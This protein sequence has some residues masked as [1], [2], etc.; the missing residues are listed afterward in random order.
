GRAALE[1][2]PGE[3]GRQV[4]A[5]EIAEPVAEAR[6]EGN[7][8][9]K[10][11]FV[12]ILRHAGFRNARP[13]ALGPARIAEIAAHVETLGRS[14]FRHVDLRR[15]DDLDVACGSARR[16]KRGSGGKGKRY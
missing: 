15:V 8:T 11:G 12:E 5:N 9:G 14:A 2:A 16:G 10:A 1:T 4:G 6:T 13:P 7:R 3:I